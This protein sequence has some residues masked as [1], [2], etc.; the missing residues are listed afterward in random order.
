M[1]KEEKEKYVRVCPKCR[2]LDV[3]SD[4][5][6]AFLG[7][8]STLKCRECGYTNTFFPEVEATRVKEFI[9]G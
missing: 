7:E 1:A 2:S 6:L 3:V 4:L 5:T 8:N 9:N